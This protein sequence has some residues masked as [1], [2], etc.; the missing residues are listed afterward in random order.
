VDVAGLVSSP[1]VPA[2]NLNAVGFA[3]VTAQLVRVL[4][5]RQPNFAVGLKEVQVQFVFGWQGFSGRVADPPAVNTVTAGSTVALRFGLG[6][7]QGL[8]VLA[9]GYPRLQ[10]VF[11][12]TTTPSGAAVSGGRA[13]GLRYDPSTGQY[14]FTW[15]TDKSWSGTCGRL[16]LKLTD[17]TTHSAY[18]SFR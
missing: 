5:T 13:T 11:C 10:P 1:A 3:P 17:G 9:T 16:D 8:S 2:P 4:M 12:G 18:V 15:S 7:D 14:V 6:G